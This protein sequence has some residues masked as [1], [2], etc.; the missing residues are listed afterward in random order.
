[1]TPLSTHPPHARHATAPLTFAGRAG[2]G[3]ATVIGV[4]QIVNF[5]RAFGDP[6]GFSDYM[7]LAVGD[8]ASG[9]VLVYGLRS[10]FIGAL[11]LACVWRREVRLL[12]LMA[13]LAVVMPAG[14]AWLAHD[15]GAPGAT[16]ARHAGIAIYLLL[17]AALLGVGA[18]GRTAAR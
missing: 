7:G 11:V 13:A 10:L 18:R 4:F 17:T 3:L 1:M 16:V 12:A 5:A 14:D 9:F 2:L 6:V 8:G 15:A